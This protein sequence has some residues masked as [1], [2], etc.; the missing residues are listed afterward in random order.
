L[1]KVVVGESGCSIIRGELT[2][3][4]DEDHGEDE[5]PEAMSV[6]TPDV[7][8]TLIGSAETTTGSNLIVGPT[9]SISLPGSV[10]PELPA[11]EDAP[12]VVKAEVGASGT[13]VG[14]LDPLVDNPGTVIGPCEAES[15]GELDV[16]AGELTGACGA[17]EVSAFPSSEMAILAT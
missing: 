2:S 16:G 3:G 12:P 7:I 8:L 1:I 17:G 4:A 10:I 6:A 9:G 5:A 14:P 15:F 13:P 11:V